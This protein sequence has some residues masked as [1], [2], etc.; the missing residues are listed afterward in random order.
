RLQGAR[1][2]ENTTVTGFRV[3]NGRVTGVSTEAGDIHCEV[4]VNCGGMWAR[5]IGRMA[6]VVVPLHAAEHFYIGTEPLAGVTSGLPT[7]RDPDGYIYV[8]G[9]G[10][11]LLMGG[12]EPNA[13]PWGMRGMPRGFAFCVL[14]D[15]WDHF[16]VFMES[17]CAR[18]P[19]LETA[20]IRRHVNGPESFT[21]DTRFILGEAPGLTGFFVA[22]GFNSTGIGSAAGAGKALAEW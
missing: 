10:G 1:I 20:G 6:G 12:F 11:G 13:E 7:L 3:A 8:P 14:P 21:P 5:D 19:A 16:Q 2:R 22:A 4:V 18:I 9:G 17:G 15:D